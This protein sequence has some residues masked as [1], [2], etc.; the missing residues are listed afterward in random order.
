MKISDKIA[1]ALQREIL[2]RR[3]NP[4]YW[5]WAPIEAATRGFEASKKPLSE[6]KLRSTECT[7][8]YVC[9]EKGSS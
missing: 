3:E 5:Y 4:T 9:C 1:N 7:S 2:L 6:V 8:S